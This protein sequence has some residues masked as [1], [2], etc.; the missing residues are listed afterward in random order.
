MEAWKSPEQS[1]LIHEKSVFF[2]NLDNDKSLD[3]IEARE[4]L[5]LEARSPLI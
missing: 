3:P 2:A 1:F 4:K 5:L